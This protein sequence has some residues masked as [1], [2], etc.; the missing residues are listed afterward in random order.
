MVL[1]SG[2]SIAGF[3]VAVTTDV[4]AGFSVT[5]SSASEDVRVIRPR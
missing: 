3:V 2:H 5:P 1:L 4:F